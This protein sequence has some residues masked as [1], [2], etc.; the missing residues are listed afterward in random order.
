MRFITFALSFALVLLP[1]LASSEILSTTDKVVAKFMQLD[2][3]ES[4]TVSFE[5][6]EQLVL[7]RMGERFTAMDTNEDNEISEEE[8]RAFWTN[9][10]AQYY[11]PIR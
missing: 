3:D 2:T 8:Y 5:E 11:R 9:Q 4:L 1:T 10:K 7:L 6:Y